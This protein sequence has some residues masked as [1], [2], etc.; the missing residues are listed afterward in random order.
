MHKLI[1]AVPFLAFHQNFIDFDCG[2]VKKTFSKTESRQILFQRKKQSQKLF[3]NPE[4]KIWI[5]QK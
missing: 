1:T 3:R 4:S 2:K 5:C